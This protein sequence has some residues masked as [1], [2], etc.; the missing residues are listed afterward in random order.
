MLRASLGRSPA[1][2]LSSHF[3]E[4]LCVRGLFTIYSTLLALC[5][6]R[7]VTGVV[8]VAP[9]FS[10]TQKQLSSEKSGVRPKNEETAFRGS[11]WCYGWG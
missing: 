2:S 5:S 9:P 11:R 4:L 10:S 8:R 6:A 3:A 7:Q 1:Q